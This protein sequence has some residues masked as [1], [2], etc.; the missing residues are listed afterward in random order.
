MAS[1]LPSHL[2]ETYDSYKR[3]TA[4]VIAWLHQAVNKAEI[5]K[6]VNKVREIEDLAA[7]AVKKPV[8]VP[9]YIL[10][11]L[12]RTIRERVKVGKFFQGDVGP[13]QKNSNANHLY[14]TGVLIRV[15]E[16]LYPL[17]N[18]DDVK[19]QQPNEVSTGVDHVVNI[20][21]LLDCAECTE[22]DGTNSVVYRETLKGRES[23]RPKKS[24]AKKSRDIISEYMD[25][26]RCLKVS[27]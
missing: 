4:E 16:S 3:G 25:I 10:Q 13:E 8:I 21:E 1:V 20:F 23:K 18:P 24:I 17:V 12:K 26:C 15:Y 27:F 6:F 19:A 2:Y 22:D 5:C 11:S 7:T 14:F 9:L